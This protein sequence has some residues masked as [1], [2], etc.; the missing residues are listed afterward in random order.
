MYSEIN[1]KME[2]A[3]QGNARLKKIDS[4]LES[5]KK[6]K[7]SISLKCSELKNILDKENKDVEKIEKKSISNIFYSIVGTLDKHIEK[8][9]QEAISAN[10]K[11][12]QALKDFEDIEYQIKKLLDERKKYIIC[13]QE[14]DYLYLQKKEQLMHEND[15]IAQEII[16]IT[17]NINNSKCNLKEIQEATMAGKRVLLSIEKALSNLKSAENWG[18]WDLLGGGFISDMAKHS[19]IDNATSEIENTQI[20]LR[21]FKSE[22]CDISISS[23][24]GIEISGFSKFADFFFDGLIAD[25]FMQSKINKSQNSIINVE[26]QVQNVIGK[27]R[28]IENDEITKIN[29]LERQIDE[30]IKNQ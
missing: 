23:D 5:L 2:E 17:D 30:I 4:I 3:M 7:N 11:Y 12:N 21:N 22:L 29:V 20:L 13:Q 1:K 27:L 8:E 28:K 19:Q 25:W 24:I 9:Q 6:D 10:F 26:N 16:R 15:K 18:T 14:Y